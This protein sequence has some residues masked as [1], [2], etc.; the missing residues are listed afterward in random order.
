MKYL[1]AFFVTALLLLSVSCSIVGGEKVNGDGNIVTNARAV[2]EF[3]SV[4]ADGAVELILATGNTGN[5]VEVKVDQ[6]LQ[7]YVKVKVEGEVL[8]ISQQSGYNLR[9]TDR[10]QVFVVAPY[11]RK[12]DVSGA[13]QIKSEDRLYNSGE[14]EISASG[15]GE[16]EMDLHAP[17]VILDLTGAG[18]VKLKGET[19]NFE[20]QLSGAADAKCS[21]LLSEYSKVDITGA[22]SA[23]LFASVRLE[24]TISGA[25]AVKYRGNPTFVTQ[26]VSGAGSI[27]KM[28]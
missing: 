13:C 12:L 27:S 18:S 21:E 28:E 19:Q 26:H 3:N 14:L 20:L 1:F 11:F 7:S 9:P 24:A 4:E 6:N 23:E 25:G 2:G 10:I 17:K 22:G 8:K 5:K 16:V 15:A